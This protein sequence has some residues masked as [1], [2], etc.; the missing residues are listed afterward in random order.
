MTVGLVV[1]SHSRKIAE[2]AVELAAQMAG[3]VT[4]VAAGGTD[5]DGIGTSFEKV[6]AALA[7][8][9]SGD[10][11]VVL[12][13]LGSAVM[14]AETA[15][16]FLDDE[17][18]VRIADAPVVEGA[19][20]AAVA[21]QGGGDLAAVLAAAQEAAGTG[22][23]SSAS[24]C[25]QPAVAQEGDRVER[26]VTVVNHVG[27]HARP[28][29]QFVAVAREFDAEVLVNDADATSLLEVMALGARQGAT[30]HLVGSGAQ[31]QEAVDA[32]GDLIESGFG[33]D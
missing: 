4:L 13:D 11:V 33:E 9:D 10:G 23:P 15:L 6:Q 32:L 8:A 28:A 31:A 19:V 25:A 26:T 24:T 12:C 30:L 27:L 1:V 20:S 7:E 29:A 3:S 5:E 16:E 14:T 2:G 17:T 22:S 18:S 21:A